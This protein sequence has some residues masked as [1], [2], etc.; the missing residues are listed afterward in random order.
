MAAPRDRLD[1]AAALA[2]R[3]LDVVGLDGGDGAL[4]DLPAVA[5]APVGAAV[6]VALDDRELVR[7]RPEAGRARLDVLAAQAV[8]DDVRLA[9]DAAHLLLG[10]HAQGLLALLHEV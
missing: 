5:E 9:R 3:Q 1:G 2:D 4:P 10:L 6:A 7:R 8:E